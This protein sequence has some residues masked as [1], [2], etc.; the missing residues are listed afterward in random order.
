MQG[1][2]SS[3]ELADTTCGLDPLLGLRGELLG[4]DNA[5]HGG[6]GARSEYLE[7]ALAYYL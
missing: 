4:A 1:G 2:G 3:D 7:E 5:G 6:E